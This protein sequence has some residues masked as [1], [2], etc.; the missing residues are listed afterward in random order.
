MVDLLQQIDREFDDFAPV[1]KL[2]LPNKSL[3]AAYEE[4]AT[5]VAQPA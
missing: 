3:V 4:V 1:L 5:A 2:G